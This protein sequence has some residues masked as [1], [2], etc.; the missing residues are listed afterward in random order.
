MFFI[1]SSSETGQEILKYIRPTVFSEQNKVLKPLL[2][3]ML[4]LESTEVPSNGITPVKFKASEKFPNTVWY[5]CSKLPPSLF[6]MF[7]KVIF[8][9]RYVCYKL[10]LF[11]V[12]Q[13]SNSCEAVFG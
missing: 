6:N 3:L 1:F 2:I 7:S 4:N 12:N 10:L 11:P 9:I 8:P 5:F 13:Y